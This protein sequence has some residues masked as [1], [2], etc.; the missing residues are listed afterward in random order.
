MLRRG[1]GSDAIVGLPMR[2][3]PSTVGEPAIAASGASKGLDRPHSWSRSI[4]SV[5]WFM[6]WNPTPF[7]D[8]QRW[9]RWS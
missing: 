2:K 9:A 8:A 3:A 5:T 4:R 7:A 1:L 6:C